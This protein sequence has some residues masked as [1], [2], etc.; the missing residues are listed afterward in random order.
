MKP[1]LLASVLC[2]APFAKGIEVDAAKF[3]ELSF[4]Y[5]IVGG[6]TTGLAVAARLSDDPSI[7][8][9]VIEAGKNLEDN[10]VLIPGLGSSGVGN[11]IYD[12]LLSTS[13]Q[14]ELNNRSFDLGRGKLLGGTSAMNLMQ[15]TKASKR[16]YDDWGLLGNP[17]WSFVDIQGFMKKSERW[18]P[19]DPQTVAMFAADNH[20]PDHGKNGSIH[21]TGNT[22]YTDLIPQ[23]LDSLSN[24][25]GVPRNL[26]PLGGNAVGSMSVTVT[27]DAQNRSRSFSNNGYYQIRSSRPNLIVLTG[28]E[29]FGLETDKRKEGLVATKV[30][31]I[32]ETN[33]TFSVS[34]GSEVVISAGS[35]K[36]PQILEQSGI[37]DPKIL[38]NAGIDIKL[39]L[40]GVGSNFQD[41][42]SVPLSFE[43]F[44]NITTFDAVRDPSLFPA[45]L[46]EYETNRT[47]LLGG[48]P[49]TT[50]F[51]PLNK[52]MSAPD[53]AKLKLA[54][55]HDLSRITSPHKKLLEVQRSWLDD[56]SVPQLELAFFAGSTTA[57][58]NP[59]ARF[60]SCVV[61]CLHPFAR[62][63]VHITDNTERSIPTINP[64]FLNSPGD[65]DRQVLLY[66][67]RYVLSLAQ[68][69][70]L[71]SF[72]TSIATGPPF[73]ATDE[74]LIAWIRDNAGSDL[75][76][77]GSAAMLPQHLGGVVDSNFLVHGTTNVR[78]A[79]MSIWPLQL[80]AHPTA[81][82]YGTAEKAVHVILD[83]RKV[84]SL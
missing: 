21:T 27:V 32:A 81:T 41:H 20:E 30:N 64:E 61:V 83:T 78:V 57:T 56:N 75:H 16:E 62:G 60:W 31:Y 77:T 48:P 26:A 42:I 46:Q 43:T 38:N 11:P 80:S 67:L 47:G 7:S 17:G 33:E 44:A 13:P 79:D 71:R 54:L 25:S 1:F 12:W 6:G 55:D 18:T 4:D 15:Y 2:T 5:I 19:P 40:P 3:S 66:G 34:V 82:L 76:P 35:V 68:T 63:D 9:G 49:S 65:F 14:P 36:T 24:L 52:F 50:A 45:L 37:G 23:Y 69:E 74:Q 59:K 28:A 51:L 39:D 58:P 29:V 72:T 84:R 53:I 73:N 70:P 10:I 22:N 8:V